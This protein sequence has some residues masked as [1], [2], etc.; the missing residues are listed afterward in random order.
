MNAWQAKQ[1]RAIFRRDILALVEAQK[2]VI[3]ALV[4]RQDKLE[5]DIAALKRGSVSVTV[6]KDAETVP[7]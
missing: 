2:G 4:R 7:A 6:T 3:S 5:A 1:E